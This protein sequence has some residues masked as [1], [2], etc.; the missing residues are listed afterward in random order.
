MISL[1][2]LA[3]TE[4]KLARC[5]DSGSE[6]RVIRDIGLLSYLHINIVTLLYSGPLVGGGIFCCG[7][8]ATGHYRQSHYRFDNAV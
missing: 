8:S 5:R 7:M 4:T 6:H 1:C 3:R 2:H